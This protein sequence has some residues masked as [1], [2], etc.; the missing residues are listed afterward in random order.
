MAYM[1]YYRSCLNQKEQKAYDIL[2]EGI[3][4]R[5]DEISVPAINEHELER[6]HTAV[7]YDYPD[8]FYVNFY[9]YKYIIGKYHTEIQINYT[10][11]AKEAS[12][13]KRDID[14]V[15]NQI[16]AKSKNLSELEAERYLNDELRKNAVYGKTEGKEFN[17]QNL[18]GAFLDGKC[19]CEGFAKAFKY[20][21]DMI[22]LKSIIAVGYAGTKS[23]EIERH[24]WNIVRIDSQSY[25][26]DV[27][28]NNVEYDDGGKNIIYFS[29]AYFN[30]SDRE[31]M[32]DHVMDTMF[33]LPKCQESR[34]EVNIIS[35]TKGL[36]SFLK[37]EAERGN[38][39]SE[40]RL[41]KEFEIEEI[42]ELIR[43]RI[44]PED[45]EWYNKIERYVLGDYSLIIEWA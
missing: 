35:S 7:N 42:I 18:M 6:V 19:V 17:A 20:L 41:T 8:F 27:T 15:A 40:L 29:R 9:S 28:Y 32:R 11:S 45:Y 36:L 26:L 30:L 43:S 22:K 5:K 3:A 31:I 39:F 12:K 38:R 34:S 14:K 37:N 23:G 4:R 33:T 13:I 24:A 25:H 2:V 44:T 10:M 1:C 16:V 21:A